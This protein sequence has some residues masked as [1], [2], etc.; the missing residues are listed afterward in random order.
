MSVP[1]ALIV[2]AA[3][4]G[5]RSIR[6]IS[7]LVPELIEV[8]S[9]EL[10]GRDGINCGRVSVRG[11]P[12]QATDCA[13]AANQA[14]KPFRVIYNRMGFDSS[15]AVAIVR[16]PSGAVTSLFYDSDPT[17]AGIRFFQVIDSKPCPVPVHLW[18]NPSGRI[19]CFQPETSAPQDI[20]SP[21]AEP[22]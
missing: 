9:K 6:L 4:N 7:H 13:L 1:V 22:Y 8:R 16:T 21:N 19:N 17:G 3:L 14:G 15:I 18:V 5:P 20:M 10:A 12:K 11:N 2:V